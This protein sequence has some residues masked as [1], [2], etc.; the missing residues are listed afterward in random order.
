MTFN[1]SIT[2]DIS[3]NNWNDN[4]LFPKELYLDTNLALMLVLRKPNFYIIE[5][6]MKE[7]AINRSNDIFWSTMTERELLE[8]IHVDT[9]KNR[10]SSLGYKPVDWKK[11]ENEISN[12][13]SAR[14]NKESN[15][16]FS[17]AINVLKQYGDVLD[18]VSP[19]GSTGALNST[20]EDAQKIYTTYG[21]GIKDAEHLAIANAYGIN[22]ILTNDSANGNGFLRYPQQNIFGISNTIKDKYQVGTTPNIY[23]NII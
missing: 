1:A 5:D 7:F 16:R 8:C 23:K 6:F 18:D 11:M 20:R 19:V 3:K 9:L 17:S 21:G 22:N 12:N 15:Q 4:N 10:A 2:F 14:I 13:D